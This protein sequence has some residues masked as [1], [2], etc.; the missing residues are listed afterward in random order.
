M[1]P[2]HL[3]IIA[4]VILVLFGAQKIPQFMRGLGQ[5]M[6]EFKKGMEESKPET[7]EAPKTE[8]K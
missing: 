6:G 4:V 7:T 1:Q 2:T 5:G 8:A 3:L